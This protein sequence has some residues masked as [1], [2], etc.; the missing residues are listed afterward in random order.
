MGASEPWRELMGQERQLNSQ[1]L[2]SG[3]RQPGFKSGSTTSCAILGKLPWTGPINIHSTDVPS[4]ISKL[5]TLKWRP[6][7]HRQGSRC[8][9]GSTEQ[10]CLYET[11][12]GKEGKWVP[13]GSQFCHPPAKQKQGDWSLALWVY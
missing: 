5:R 7:L 9:L 13:H 8:L 2:D 4:S 1:S 10:V 11:Q 12:E 6:P 3:A